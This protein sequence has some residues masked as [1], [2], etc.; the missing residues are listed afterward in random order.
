MK[1]NFGK[2]ELSLEEIEELGGQIT[3]DY[4]GESA[5]VRFRLKERILLSGI[6]TWTGLF[7]SALNSGP[8]F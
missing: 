8:V 4:I 6:W 7:Q 3:D 2:R 1:M 5:S